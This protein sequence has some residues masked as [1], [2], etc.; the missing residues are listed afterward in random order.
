[1]HRPLDVVELYL[2][3]PKRPV[4]PSE[5][6][7]PPELFVGRAGKAKATG[8]GAQEKATVTGPMTPSTFGH[9]WKSPR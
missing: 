3:G 9:L 7:L 1:M 2:D 6:G 4:W 8:F 5:E